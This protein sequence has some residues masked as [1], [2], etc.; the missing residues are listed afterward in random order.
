MKNTSRYLLTAVA[1][2][3]FAMVS[4]VNARAQYYDLV[5]QIPNLI[6]PALSG[7][8]NYKGY[9]DATATFGIGHNRANF[10]G[11]STSQGFRYSNWFF[12]GAGVGIDLVTSSIN[13]R[14]NLDFAPYPITRATSRTKAMIPI[15]SDFRFNIG[16]N[17]GASVFLDIKAGATWLIGSSYLELN[18]GALSNRAQFLLRP[19]LGVRLPVVSK[20][21]KSALNIG[22]TYQLITADNSWGYWNNNFSPTLNSL[23]VNIGYEW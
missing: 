2:F 13:D 19:S 21:P 1:S 20:N 18:D 12:M 22:V 14:D 7:S 8:L 15:F 16:N 5:S 4:T 11:L 6:S 3:V 17:G 23:G 9:V 10:V